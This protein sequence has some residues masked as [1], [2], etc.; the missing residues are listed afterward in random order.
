MYGSGE[1]RARLAARDGSL[2]SHRSDYPAG[3]G[4]EIYNIGGHNERTNLQVVGAILRRLGKPD[5]LIDHVAD[6]KGHDL[7]YAIDPAK[8]IGSW[9]GCPPRILIA[10]SRRPST[11]M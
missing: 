10:A 8:S 1:E 2:R 3:S 7:R 6:R 4:G 9:A 11:G 5:S